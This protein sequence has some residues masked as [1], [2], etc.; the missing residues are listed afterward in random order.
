[1][2][3]VDEKDKFIKLF[4]K[5]KKTKKKLEKSLSKE[6]E[7]PFDLI[8]SECPCLTIISGSIGGGKT[9]FVKALILQAQKKKAFHSII[10]I[11]PTIFSSDWTA[12]GIPEECQ[13][14]NVTVEQLKELEKLQKEALLEGDMKQY[15][16]VFDDILGGDTDAR[17]K[18]LMQLVTI[19]RHVGIT[20]VLLTQN[21]KGLGTT[22]RSNCKFS[23]L[24]RTSGMGSLNIL[25]QEMSNGE[26]KQEFID[27]FIN[28]TNDYGCLF[29][30]HYCK[31]LKDKTR[32]FKVNMKYWGLDKKHNNL[33]NKKTNKDASKT[34]KPQ[35]NNRELYNNAFS[36][37][38]K[39][40]GKSKYKNPYRK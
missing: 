36:T 3:D 2:A 1:M 8:L 20:C 15:M 10:V 12:L 7:E 26:S 32:P 9:V 39:A 5:L 38:I 29:N 18:G 34:E 6:Q 4:S 13:M 14:Q 27:N 21:I 28:A 30:Y 25:Y 11:S 19:L 17:G 37:T 35:F 22:M 40:K 33:K 24:F 16:L 31:D 23:C